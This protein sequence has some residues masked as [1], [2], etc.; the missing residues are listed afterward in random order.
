MKSIRSVVTTLIFIIYCLEVAVYAE[1]ANVTGKIQFEKRIYTN[2]LT[3]NLNQVDQLTAL[4]GATVIATSQ[5]STVATTTTDSSGNYSFSFNFT[6]TFNLLVQ[7]KNDT[8]QVGN[9][10]EE[11]ILSGIYSNDI[12]KL[13]SSSG[14]YNKDISISENSGAYNIYS[15]LKKGVDW[16]Q[17]QSYSFTKTVKAV[18][19]WS[20]TFFETG[21]NAIYLLG[22]MGT[23]T[24]PDEFDDDVILHEF[25][26][27]FAENFS[28]DHSLGGGHS[29]DSKVD[30]RL[31]WSEG[32]A[33]Y[34]SCAIRGE[35]TY[36]DSSGFQSDGKSSVSAY[37]H[38]SPAVAATEAH[39]E[40]AVTY[41]LL[42]A[43]KKSN[44]ASVISTVAGFKS[45]PT[46]LANEQ[47]SMDT[48]H[49][50]WSGANLVDYY[51]NRS[52]SYFNDSLSGN[53]SSS[54]Y[55]LSGNQTLS[56]LSFYSNGGSDYFI[57]SVNAGDTLTLETLN[58]KNGALTSIH[59][60]KGS[61][62]SDALLTSND[63]TNGS[64][65][66]STSKVSFS[67]ES[68]GNY[69][70]KVSRFN[71]SSN[72]YGPYRSSYTK[73]VGRYGNYD[74][75][76]TVLNAQTSSL[77][78]DSTDS[79]VEGMLASIASNNTENSLITE[80][81]ALNVVSAGQ[82]RQFNS[83]DTYVTTIAT[84]VESSVTHNDTTFSTTLSN[85][86]E[87]KTLVYGT[88]PLSTQAN[89]PVGSTG[90]LMIFNMKDS[91]NVVVSSGFN[92]KIAFNNISTSGSY[93][94]Y[95]RQSDGTFSDSEFVGSIENS[96]LSFILTHFSAYALVNEALLS[97][98]SGT[99]TTSSSLTSSS[100]AGGGGGGCFLNFSY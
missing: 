65:T 59:V 57:A 28:V 87:N 73:T 16:F 70:F 77:T 60:Y 72:D 2:P 50:L 78:K 58:T 17:S 29:P 33:T 45:L 69:L 24:D 55:Q 92:I 14:T 19:P 47:I 31:A 81:E 32:F 62:E 91:N 27:F 66:D 93:K 18:W 71:S 54:P 4:D 30:L 51:L 76:F 7:A 94:L 90:K 88:V 20:G 43:A 41:I 6:G 42:E 10:I 84:Q 83:G 36:I 44:D 99:S 97:S 67:A 5:G 79:E 39:N 96:E 26:H 34:V 52:M 100:S 15:Q 53:T 9:K 35:T 23:N 74:I 8:I 68:S 37:D 75:K 3:T 64:L 12:V 56:N 89:A 85:I 38:S 46:P 63:P 86:P 48:F 82:T 11:S 25:G 61:T 95:V 40:A 22:V 49:D 21:S 98:T 1:T 80:I 13:Q